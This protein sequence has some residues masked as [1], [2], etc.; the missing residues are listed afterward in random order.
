VKSRNDPGV[1]KA[2]RSLPGRIPGTGVK[3][4]AFVFLC[5]AQTA[6]ADRVTVRV[7]DSAGETAYIEPGTA[8]GLSKGMRVRIGGRDVTLAECTEKSCSVSTGKNPLPIGATGTADAAAKAGA[9]TPAEGPET[10]QK[11][12]APKPLEAFRDQWPAAV[13]P[14]TQQK[15]DAVPLGET[16]A[17]GTSHV[18]IYGH[19]AG[20]LD[21]D[22][23]GGQIEGQVVASFDR[24]SDSPLGAD[25][26]A[27]VRLFGTGF[28]T[29]SRVP[30]FVRAAMLRWGDANDPSIAVGRLRYAATSVG[31]LDGG[32][33]AF[34]TGHLELA[35]YGGLV[36]DPISGAP[37][38]GA[39]RFGAE[40]IYDSPT[41][42]HPRLAVNAH[43]STWSGAVDEKILSVAASANK[44]AL[45]F[46]GFADVQ[47]FDA[48]NPWGAPA[49][50]L[51]GAGASGEWRHRGNHVGVDVTFLRPERSMR[52][53]AALR[54]EASWL[55]ATKTLPGMMPES[56][57]GNDFW[58]AT[59]VSGGF[60]GSGYS[61]DAV[62][63]LGTTQS[64]DQ[65]GD[66]SG[67]VRS[68]L[69]PRATRAVLAVSG[70]HAAFAAWEAADIGFALSPSP[71]LDFALT[72]RPER[73]D[74]I[75]ATDAFVLHNLVTDLHYSVSAAFDIAVS[76]VGTT[77][78][79]RDVLTLLTTLA[80]RPLP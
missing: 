66:L 77:G 2:R 55:C 44:D 48:N 8:A 11:L 56:C 72:Y 7:V 29:G 5:I 70:G 61:V 46:N 49:V 3:R 12:P 76:A 30:L 42:W 16:A 27:A 14:A 79:D 21:K 71:R 32:R 15:V 80:W 78:Q 25:V 35:A 52:L 60:A 24:I 10:G 37:S 63:S 9:A 22:G 4:L 6:Y 53:A 40:A 64:L 47:M 50:D 62:G 57:L 19:M 67:Y 54:D 23:S 20:N 13:L 34:R 43:G 73:L 28:D 1:P 18:A 33:A 31:M 74:Y 65:Q 39:S 75:A 58:L 59:T 69:G 38:S 17:R 36:P 45:F 26:D 41:G 51:T 68:E